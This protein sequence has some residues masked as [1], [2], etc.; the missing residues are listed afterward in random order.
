MSA[1]GY[2]N[3]SNRA[4]FLIQTDGQENSSTQYG[5]TQIKKMIATAEARGWDFQFIGTGV[6]AIQEGEKFGLHASKCETFAKTTRGFEMMGSSLSTV[7]TSYR[8]KI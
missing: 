7:S 4:I 1:I 6:D 2:A 5:G 3:E 8:T